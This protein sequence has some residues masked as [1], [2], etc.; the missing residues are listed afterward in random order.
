MTSNTMTLTEKYYDINTM[1]ELYNMLEE[2]KGDMKDNVYK[3]LV[4]KMG[5]IILNPKV[6][7]NSHPG[8]ILTDIEISMYKEMYPFFYKLGRII[9]KE[10]KIRERYKY[11]EFYE[12]TIEKYNC[13]TG[14]VKNEEEEG[15]KIIGDFRTKYEYYKCEDIIDEDVNEEDENKETWKLVNIHK[16]Y[17]L[18][19][20]V[21]LCKG[22]EKNDKIFKFINEGNM[23]KVFE[24]IGLCVIDENNRFVSDK[25]SITRM[26]KPELDYLF[27]N[28]FN[29]EIYDEEKEKWI[30]Y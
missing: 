16:D 1:Y 18:I 25:L 19:F 30:I 24:I 7:N 9:P 3:C 28:K 15:Y 22:G 12:E 11:S 10:Y 8:R 5:K 20:L 6:I 14:D 21:K 26:D 17:E 27:R 13:L 4:E 23:N 29:R 2:N